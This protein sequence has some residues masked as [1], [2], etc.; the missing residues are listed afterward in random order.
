M[1]NRAP[2][3][4]FAI[5]ESSSREAV[6]AEMVGL[7]GTGGLI[8][9]TPWGHQGYAFRTPGMYRG[10]ASSDGAHSVAVYGDE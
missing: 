6:M 2:E 7:G 8:Y 5:S 4:E 10:M 3:A 1:Q 9:L